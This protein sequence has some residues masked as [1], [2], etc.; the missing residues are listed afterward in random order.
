MSI[1]TT[2]Q[3]ALRRLPYQP[4]LALS[5]R[6]MATEPTSQTPIEDSIRQKVDPVPFLI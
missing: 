2:A 1:R 5:Q 4:R 6:F 3:S